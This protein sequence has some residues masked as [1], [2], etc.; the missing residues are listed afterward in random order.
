MKRILF[1]IAVAVIVLSSAFAAQERTSTSGSGIRAAS[2]YLDSRMD[3]WLHWP[4]AARDHDTQCVSC[5]TAL[6]YA[7]ARPALRKFLGQDELAAPERSLLANVIKRV[8]LWK[9]VEPFY[10]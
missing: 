10:P 6:P 7:V 5:H 9:E 2:A 8:K 1:G 3:W 4:N